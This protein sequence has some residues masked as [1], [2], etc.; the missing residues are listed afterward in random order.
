MS[1]YG[2]HPRLSRKT[3][4]SNDVVWHWFVYN[5]PHG[6]RFKW[7][8]PILGAGGELR[9]LREFI[10]EQAA[11]IPDFEAHARAIS[12]ESLQSSDPV[13]VLKGIHVLAAI[14]KDEEMLLVVPLTD[15]DNPEVATHARTALFERGIKKSRNSEL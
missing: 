7:V 12:I 11:A 14:G 6:E 3:P 9:L 4:A 2:K 15:S 1:L 5:G 10:N 13:L 8:D